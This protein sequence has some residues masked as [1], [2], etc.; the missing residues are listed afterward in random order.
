ML[1]AA[2][3]GGIASGKSTV[4]GMFRE[5]GA[6]VIESDHMAHKAVEAPSPLL[7][8]LVEIFGPEVLDAQGHLRRRFLRD[9]VFG[10]EAARMQLNNLLHPHIKNMLLSE[11]DKIKD[12]GAIVLVD[13]PLL[14]ETG[15]DKDFS[16]IILSYVSPEIQLHRLMSRDGLSRETAEVALAAQMPIDKKKQKSQFIIDNSGLLPETLAQVQD[17]WPA[18]QKISANQTQLIK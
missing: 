9:I 2:L 1:K 11:M 17:T 18:L 4:G 6:H 15:W 3:T 13:V 7:P 10:D 12:P 8:R 5:L 14:F 16:T